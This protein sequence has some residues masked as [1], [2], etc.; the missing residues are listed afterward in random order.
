MCAQLGARDDC[1]VIE[2]GYVE[3]EIIDDF[4]VNELNDLKFVQKK[5]KIALCLL[6]QA[7]DKSGFEK[8]A[9]AVNSKQAQEFWR[10]YSEVLI[11]LNKYNFNTTRELEAMKMKE[12]D[13]IAKYNTRVQ[14]VVNQLKRNG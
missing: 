11:M 6:F 9:I 2:I 8:I 5:D 1:D 4:T 10:K 12:L 3:P 14:Y 7:A 13:G